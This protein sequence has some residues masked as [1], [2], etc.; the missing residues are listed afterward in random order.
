M[1]TKKQISPK[2][3]IAV[4]DFD[5]TISLANAGG[6]CWFYIWEKIGAC[7]QDEYYANMFYSGQITDEEWSKLVIDEYRKRGVTK[8]LVESVAENLCVRKGTKQTFEELKKRNIKIFIISGGIKQI[9]ERCVRDFRDLIDE[10]VCEELLF[11]KD[12]LVCGSIKANFDTERKEKYI[13]EL[14][15]RFKVSPSEIFFMGNGNNDESV[16]LSGATTLCINP[17][18]TNPYDK[19]C[20]DFYI[21]NLTNFK[22]ILPFV[23]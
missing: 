20:W 17:H 9:V 5:G 19:N 15:K 2:T 13:F 10:I 22:Q 23:K 11:D 6:N 16:H 21:E 12:G 7:E 4:F 1:T 3:K 14:A 18:K 8:K